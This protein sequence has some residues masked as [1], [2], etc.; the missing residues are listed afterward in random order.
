MNARSY[1]DF[2]CKLVLKELATFS[3][4]DAERG[5]FIRT[6][7]RSGPRRNQTIG[8]AIGSIIGEYNTVYLFG[9]H[10]RIS[11]LV[12][13]ATHEEWAPNNLDHID[14]NTLNNHI[15]NLRCAGN[16]LNTKNQKIRITNTSGFTG[17]YLIKPSGRFQSSARINGRNHS[18]GYYDTA[19]EAYIARKMAIAAHPEWGFTERHGE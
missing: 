17:V 8:D 10:F 11:H 4:Y 7:I 1:K 15:S 14:G 19:E 3:I 9:F 2:D 6:A 12:W 5:A 18:F 13:A 16:L